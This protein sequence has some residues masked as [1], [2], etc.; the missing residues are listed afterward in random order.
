MKPV[1]WGLII[2]T[3]ISLQLSAQTIPENAYGLRVVNTP[4]LHRELVSRDS[5]LQMVNLR[6]YIPGL[7]CRIYYAT[8]QNFVHRRLYR[9]PGVFLR[10]PA[11]E[12]L[13]AVQ[14]DLRP[15]GLG[16][17]IF[18]AY[19]PYTVTREMWKVV[20]DDQYAA[21]P[22]HGSAHNRGAAVDLTLV[23]L[24]DARALPMGTPF[25]DFSERAHRDYHDLPD[26]I[27]ANRQLLE[28]VMTKHG[29]R[30]L[31]TEWW[32]FSFQDGGSFPLMDLSFRELARAGL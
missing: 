19:R 31:R 26:S 14:A 18:D 2:L 20:R 4:P 30:P 22:R 10:R 3:G 21:D 12:A 15:K 5:R 11:A 8:K 25:D 16:I 9:A 27:I 6:E 7:R 1:C 24:S 29:F 23:R 32:H 28:V 13:R 17:L